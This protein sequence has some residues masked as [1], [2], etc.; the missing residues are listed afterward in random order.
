MQEFSDLYEG[1]A[2]SLHHYWSG[3]VPARRHRGQRKAGTGQMRGRVQVRCCLNTSANPQT[4]CWLDLPPTQRVK[5]FEC[6]FFEQMMSNSGFIAAKCKTFFFEPIQTIYTQVNMQ[7][8]ALIL[9]YTLC[10]LLFN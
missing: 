9:W 4:S 10:Q 8:Q 6:H 2:A 1:E 7:F 3:H 5:L